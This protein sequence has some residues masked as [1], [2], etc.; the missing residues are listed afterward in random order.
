MARSSLRALPARAYEFGE[1][2]KAKVHPDYHIE[3]NRAYYSVPYRFI[4]QRLDVRV[5]ANAVEIFDAG[6]LV[7]AHPRAHE[8]GRRSTRRAHRPERHV[9]V[10]ERSLERVLERAAGVGPATHELLRL[11]AAHRKHREETLR[12]AQGI[13]RLAEDF[14]MASVLDPPELHELAR[15]HYGPDRVRDYFA[16]LG[17]DWEMIDFPTEQVV[18]QGQTVVWIGHCTWRNRHTGRLATTPKVDIW[19]FRDSRA[20]RMFEMFDTLAFV[21]A[22]GMLPQLAAV[23]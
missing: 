10:I 13:L 9:Q 19:T 15:D 4:G 22:A 14:A 21:R 8:R 11:Q 7:A 17:A 16:A 20:V 12:S 6:T 1:W 18:E 5:S 2:R 23:A 3:V